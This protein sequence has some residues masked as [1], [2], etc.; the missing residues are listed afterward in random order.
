MVK[1]RRRRAKAKVQSEKGEKTM[2]EEADKRVR[3]EVKGVSKYSTKP[4]Y[5]TVLIVQVTRESGKVLM[6]RDE[7]HQRQMNNA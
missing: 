5:C 4:R 7:V 6:M 3:V 1:Y 2:A